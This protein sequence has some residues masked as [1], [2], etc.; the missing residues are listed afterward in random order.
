VAML[1]GAAVYVPRRAKTQAVGGSS[2]APVSVAPSPVPSPAAP[3]APAPAPSAEAQAAAAK[4]AAQAAAAKAAADAAAQAAAAQAAAE[5]A[6]KAA[7]LK[8]AQ[9]QAD[10]ISSRAAAIDS[11]LTTLQRAQ[12]AQG[13]GLRGDIVAAQARMQTNLARAEAALQAQDPAAAKEYLD[14]AENDAETLERFLGR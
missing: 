2:A 13:Y 14:K 4:A 3:P 9:T 8:E 7:A 12:A 5:A 10:Q 11:S 6:A 1:A